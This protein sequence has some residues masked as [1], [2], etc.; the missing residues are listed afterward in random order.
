MTDCPSAGPSPPLI[1]A[2]DPRHPSLP[3][4]SSSSN[5]SKRR[6]S[7]CTW[8]YAIEEVQP[9]LASKPRSSC[10]LSASK[11]RERAPGPPKKWASA[12]KASE[13][14]PGGCDQISSA[15]QAS[16]KQS[17]DK[18]GALKKHGQQ[19]EA[20][21]VEESTGAGKKTENRRKRE[22]DSTSKRRKREMTPSELYFCEE[23]AQRLSNG[24]GSP[25][26]DCG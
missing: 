26:G 12:G 23:C 15:G 2:S 3:D 10:I 6:W 11:E 17:P 4:P 21:L 20:E 9:E 24:S 1:I 7:P 22:E 5:S 13:G 18:S 16:G 8:R 19:K 14:L 25:V